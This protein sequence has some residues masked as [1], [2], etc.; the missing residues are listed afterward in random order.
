MRRLERLL[1]AASDA[2]TSV[3]VSVLAATVEG[4]NAI[5]RWVYTLD[6]DPA[7]GSGSRPRNVYADESV[8]ASE[9]QALR[10]I[11]GEFSPHPA[12][13]GWIVGSGYAAVT[14]PP[15]Q[16][17]FQQWLE[18]VVP[19][20]ALR[21]RP[22]RHA[23]S[24]RDLIMSRSIDLSALERAGQTT[25]VRLDFR[26]RW[27]RE[28]ATWARFLPAYVAALGAGAPVLALDSLEMLLQPSRP[29]D[30]EEMRAIHSAGAAGLVAPAL[31]DYAEDLERRLDLTLDRGLLTANGR[32]K[33]QGA[34]WAAASA[35]MLWA[36]PPPSLDIDREAR[37]REP[38][39]TAREAFVAFAD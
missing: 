5:P 22:L 8:T 35:S 1:G 9:R 37:L 26:P 21:A 27:A 34:A 33:A 39:I 28:P 11:V 3:Q 2:G 30:A 19:F 24:A 14:P 32:L 18:T 20:D 7:G 38:E 4:M 31:F 36:D 17:A 16:G 10:E 12:V 23:F 13:T 29:G 25:L 15:S 6:P